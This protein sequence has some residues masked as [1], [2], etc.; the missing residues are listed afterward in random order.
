MP[1]RL[2]ALAAVAIAVALP[3]VSSADGSHH[4][5]DPNVQLGPRPYYL[6]ED[7]DEG[8]LKRELQSCS[9][10]PFEQT[11][12]SIGHRGACLQFPEHTKESYEA[13]A[14]MGA[15]ILECDVTFTKDRELVCRHAQCDLHTTTNILAIPAGRPSARQPFVPPDRSRTSRPKP[16]SATCC[17][18][19][20]TLAEFKTLVRQDGRLQPRRPHGRTNT[21]TARRTS[22]PTST[23]PSTAH[24]GRHPAHT[25]RASSCSRA[26][27]R[28]MTP[29]LKAPEVPMPYEG[30]YTPGGLRP[31]DDRRVQ[32]GGR[33]R[34]HVSGAQSFNLQRRAVLDRRTSRA[35][36]S[37]RSTS[38]IAQRPGATLPRSPMLQSPTG[39]RASR[40]SRR[41]MWALLTLDDRRAGSCPSDYARTRGAPA[42]TSS[43]GRSSAPG[44]S[45]TGGRLLLPVRHARRSTTTATRS[46]LL[47]VLA[48]KV[49]VLGVF[50]DW[51]AT[52]TYYANCRRRRHGHR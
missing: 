39:S 42:S 48:R 32:G 50:S 19:D 28:K 5:R 22:A 36:A 4:R 38:T 7:M 12:F 11:D 43:P 27:A 41:R 29:E 25:R 13:A 1:R 51:A 26:W 9:E 8:P 37:R 47:D 45:R 16:A 18:S 3:I 15:G 14:R 35:S 23:P 33:R 40:S 34:P 10:G 30:D 17:T 6:V 46:T 31:A 24:L 21:W 20:L 44:R 52:V 49:G 2:S